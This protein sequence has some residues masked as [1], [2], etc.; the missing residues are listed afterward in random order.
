MGVGL[1]PRRAAVLISGACTLLSLVV[2]WS[3]IR[4]QGSPWTRILALLVAAFFPGQ[5][6]QHA[7][8]PISLF[9]LATLLSLLWAGGGRWV[10]SGLAGAVAALSYPP[11][12]V[13]APMLLAHGALRWH[14]TRRRSLLW[15]AAIAAG[16]TSSGFIVVLAIHYWATGVWNAFFLVQSGYG[17]GLNFPWVAWWQSVRSVVASPWEGV[18]EAPGLQTLFVA[19]LV[20]GLCVSRIGKRLPDLEQITV[21]CVAALWLFPLLMGPGVSLYRS[22]AM[23]LPATLLMGRSHWISCTAVLLVAVTIASGMAVLFFRL[24]LV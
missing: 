4:V 1:G 12:V 8:Y 5:V 7:A 11:G 3:I 16:L 2:V 19:S 6:Y 9:T 13:L 22:E 20:V 21:L 23:L 10:L 24:N 14:S 17:H 15:G 18:W